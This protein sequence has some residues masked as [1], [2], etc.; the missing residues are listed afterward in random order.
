MGLHA[1]PLLA[2]NFFTGR[3]V[4][5]DVAH[6][7]LSCY[8]RLLPITQFDHTIEL[9]QLFADA[10]SDRRQNTLV[11]QSLL[12][13]VRQQIYGT[14]ADHGDQNDHDSL[15]SDPVF[16]L[17]ANRFPK[18]PDRASQR[19]GDSRTLSPSPIFGGSVTFSSISSSRPSTLCH[20][21]SPWTWMT[22]TIRLAANRNSLL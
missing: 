13:M 14:L 22:L 11:R 2:F 16:K 21:I 17:I 1:V 9:T 6:H 8:S 3:P 15:R 5:I 10:L 4:K 12:S 18:G 7:P 20:P 19:S